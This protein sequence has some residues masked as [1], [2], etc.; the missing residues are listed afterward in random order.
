MHRPIGIS[1]MNSN[2]AIVAETMNQLQELSLRHY[3]KDLVELLTNLDQPLVRRQYER[4]VGVMIKA[5]FAD[6]YERRPTKSAKGADWTQVEER[7]AIRFA[8]SRTWQLEFMRE[9][10]SDVRGI[11]ISKERSLQMLTYYKHETVL[12]RFIFAPFRERICGNPKASNRPAW[13]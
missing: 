4:L 2:V 12:A 1:E 9:L 3:A 7:F 5:P 8:F 13:P 11:S 6:K 10:T